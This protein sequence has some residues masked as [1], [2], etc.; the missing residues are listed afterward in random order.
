MSESP[1]TVSVVL[2]SYNRPEFLREALA[3]LL[4]QTYARLDITVVDN[5]SARSEEVARVVEEFPCV[6][7]IR[8]DRNLGYAGG[9]N[10]GIGEATGR[11]TYLTEDDIVLDA[12]CL[13]HLVEHADEHRATGLSSPL[14]YNKTARTIRCAGGEL[15]LRGVYRR[16][17]FGEGERDAGQFPQP[18]DV[19]YIDGACVFARTDFLKSLGGFREEFF[20]YVEAVEF[21]ARALKSGR[22]LTVVPAAKIYHFEPP[23]AADDAGELD[24]HKYKNL[25]ALYLLHAPARHLPEFFARYAALGLLRAVAGRGGDARA[26]VRALRWTARR[27]PSL[28]RER[29]GSLSARA[30]TSGDVPTSGVRRA[31][32]V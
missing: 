11:Y 12:D 5:R 14:M 24:F 13:R 18:F 3:S 22:K 6:R 29:R 31:P 21:C 25:F 16:T 2:L 17:T 30:E 26:L 15:S 1:S 23:E 28:L 7:L 19:G 4:A 20:M 32:L 27:T 10:R 9:M 8:N